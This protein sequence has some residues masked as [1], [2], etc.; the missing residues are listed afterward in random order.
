[1]GQRKRQQWHPP[2]GSE[3][4]KELLCEFPG[5]HSWSKKAKGRKVQKSAKP[6]NSIGSSN[7]NNIPGCIENRVHFSTLNSIETIVPHHSSQISKSNNSAFFFCLASCF[8]TPRHSVN[9][10]VRPP[11]LAESLPVCTALPAPAPC[12]FS[13]LALPR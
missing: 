7:S 12:A 10:Q 5:L 11:L 13:C 3:R 8:P 1:M 9:P 4:E 6:T 2:W